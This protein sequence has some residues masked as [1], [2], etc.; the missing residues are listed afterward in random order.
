MGELG[1]TISNS[2]GAVFLLV[3]VSRVQTKVAHWFETYR[4]VSKTISRSSYNEDILPANVEHTH[5]LLRVFQLLFKRL[6]KLFLGY[7]K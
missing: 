5:I 1:R 2:L 7:S 4:Y 3:L 6:R